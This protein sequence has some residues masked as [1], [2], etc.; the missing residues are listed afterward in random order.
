MLVALTIDGGLSDYDAK[1]VIS[2]FEVKLKI[3]I[4]KFEEYLEQTY[5]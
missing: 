5:Q 4:K 2:F 3:S 1:K